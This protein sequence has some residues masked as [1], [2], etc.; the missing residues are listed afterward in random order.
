MFTMTMGLLINSVGVRNGN[1]AISA[2]LFLGTIGTG[3]VSLKIKRM[4]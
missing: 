2:A 3:K 1:I 4:P